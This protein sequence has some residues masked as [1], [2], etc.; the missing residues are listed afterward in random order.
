MDEWTFGQYLDR[1]TALETLKNHWDTWFT[2]ADF[3]AI[4]A[5]KWG[6]VRQPVKHNADLLAAST[7]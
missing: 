2:E 6:S 7:T 5:A 4:A 3:A 1:D